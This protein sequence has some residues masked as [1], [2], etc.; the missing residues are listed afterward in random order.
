MNKLHFLHEW[1]RIRAR[2]LAG[3]VVLAS[4]GGALGFRLDPRGFAGNL[5]AELVGLALS[6]VVA[7]LIVERVTAY[8]DGLARS[9]ARELVSGRCEQ[10]IREQVFALSTTYRSLLLLVGVEVREP[11]M[12][13]R[14]YV[15]NEIEPEAMRLLLALSPVPPTLA[16]SNFEQF[17]E[18]LRPRLVTFRRAWHDISE[19]LY[20]LITNAADHP[21]I[22]RAAKVEQ[23]LRNLN[24]YIEPR[25]EAESGVPRSTLA[26]N[27]LIY[28]ACLIVS[29]S[30]LVDSTHGASDS[31][32]DLG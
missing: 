20:P 11:F 6:V 5:L 23:E 25:M 30:Q 9:S 1:R 12:M 10:P 29:L 16:D 24:E 4:A 7:A 19:D 2:F 27:I 15:R 22:Y 21:M 26:R 8:R 31:V 18:E 3:C 28:L 32:L 14:T 17:R 13:Q